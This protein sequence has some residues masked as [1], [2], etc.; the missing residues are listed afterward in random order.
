MKKVVILVVA[1]GCVAALGAY[2][3]W[4]S[5]PVAEVY[6]VQRGTAIAAVYGTVKVVPSFTIN[7]RARNSG[8]VELAD[9]LMTRQNAVG[10]AVKRGQVLANIVNEDL[11]REL[12]K[13]RTDVGSAEQRRELGP[14]S[15]PALKTG[16]AQLARL[17]KLAAL[18]NV[19]A[20]EVER[21]RNE[22]QSLK[23]RVRAEELELSRVVSI[24]REQLMILEDRKERSTIRSPIDG[25]ITVLGVANGEF[26]FENSTPFTVATASTFLEG[27]INEEDVGRVALGMKAAVKLYSYPDKEFVAIVTQVVP[28]ANDQRYTVNFTLDDPP[29]SLMSGMTGEVNVIIGKRENALIVP[30]RAVLVDRVFV[31]RDGVVKPRSV[32]VGYRSIERAEILDGLQEGEQVVVADQDLLRAG[33]RVRPITINM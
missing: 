18:N 21:V 22:A 8:V 12:S 23:E 14:P 1:V 7:I 16:E 3:F 15:L 11:D 29:D 25:V 27:Q 6:V 9:D 31:V 17:E 13:A 32:K 24:L 30:S 4:G 5:G 28:T 19:A 2:R 10:I 20:S 33:Q 26:I